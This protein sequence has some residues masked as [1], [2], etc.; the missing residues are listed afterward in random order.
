MSLE[1]WYKQPECVRVCVTY[2]PFLSPFTV[3]R[4]P[5]VASIPSIVLVAAAPVIVVSAAASAVMVPAAAAA[6]ALLLLLL[7]LVVVAVPAVGVLPVSAARTLLVVVAL[8]PAA[9]VHVGGRVRV[10]GDVVVPRAAAARRLSVRVFG[11]AAVEL[12]GLLHAVKL[13][14]VVHLRAKDRG[15]LRTQRALCKI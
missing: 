7:L 10:R 2:Y 5:S 8:V 13:P 14:H 11:E 6:T 3:T 15:I 4:V 9:A 1:N 12:L